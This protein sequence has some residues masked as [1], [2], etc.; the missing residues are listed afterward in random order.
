MTDQ[1]PSSP[2]VGM[3]KRRGQ[4]LVAG[5]AIL[6]GALGLWIWQTSGRES[7]DDAQIRAHI[8]QIGA[9]VGG[10]IESIRV[11]DN[12]YVA[13]DTVLLEIDRLTYEVAL[14]RA[15]AEL[16]DAE[17]AAQAA[18]LGLPVA[19]QTTASD[20]LTA[21]A[22]V[23]RAS[24]GVTVADKELEAAGARQ[25][26]AEARE[27][28]TEAEAERAVRDLERLEALIAR[29]EI[30]QQQYDLAVRSAE[31]ARA[32]I[33]AAAAAVAES[34][35]SVAAAA[36]RL[37]QARS[38][39]EQAKAVLLVAKTGPEQMEVTRAKANVTDAKVRQAKAA[40]R[41]AEINLDHTTV[42]AP[43]DGV[44]SRKSVEI[45]QLVAVGQPLMALVSLDDVWVIANFK[46]TQLE[47]MTPGQASTIR[48]DGLGDRVLHGEVESIAAATSAMFSLFPAENASG[49]YVKVVQRVPVK[50]IIDEGQDPDQQLR[51]GMSVVP[52][53][54]VRAR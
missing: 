34:E 40:L 30:S 52:T 17:A 6:A 47:R 2:A 22:D 45:G 31:G 48:V 16:A 50:I 20:Q 8:T 44:V 14:E 21:E 28:D 26:L 29:D 36:S 1:T 19:S 11:V 32:S 13:K 18:R 37:T 54:D 33:A 4:S 38:V 15:K 7:T 41:Q 39:A 10:A 9:R 42:R 35:A 12:Q 24:S 23:E 5:A 25:R 43:T 27:R 3:W 49:N 46:E 51:P 53:V